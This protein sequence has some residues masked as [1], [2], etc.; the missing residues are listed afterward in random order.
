[1]SKSKGYTCIVCVCVCGCGCVCVCVCVCVQQRKEEWRWVFFLAAL[2]YIFGFIFFLIFGSGDIEPWAIEPEELEVRAG[3]EMSSPP[4]LEMT[5]L[6][7]MKETQNSAVVMISRS[8][9]QLVGEELIR[10]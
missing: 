1:M 3:D 4:T 6:N 5:E 10:S 8:S 9:Q 7:N 2:I